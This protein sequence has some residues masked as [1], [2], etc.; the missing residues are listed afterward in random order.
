MNT[1]K[2]NKTKK[3]RNINTNIK[4]KLYKTKQKTNNK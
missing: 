3:K 4:K 1:I 2:K